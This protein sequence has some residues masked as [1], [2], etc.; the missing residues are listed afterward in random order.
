[1][2]GFDNLNSKILFLFA[3]FHIIEQFEIHAQLS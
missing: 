2:I 3:F 1:M